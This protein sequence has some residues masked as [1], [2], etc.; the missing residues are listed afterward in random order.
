MNVCYNPFIISYH[1]HFFYRSFYI[2]ARQITERRITGSHS[3]R[4]PP[5][6]FGTSDQ[7]AD[8]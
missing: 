1:L 2:D 6:T 3:R 7:K 5:K 4:A 8:L